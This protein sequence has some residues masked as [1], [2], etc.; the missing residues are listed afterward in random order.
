MSPIPS[1]ISL[2]KTLTRMKQQHTV[3]ACDLTRYSLLLG[4]P[5]KGSVVQNPYLGS[6]HLV[7]YRGQCC[8]T[9]KHPVSVC[10]YMHGVLSY[11]S[12]AKMPLPRQLIENTL[13]VAYSLT[14]LE[15][16]TIMA[17]GRYTWC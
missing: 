10:M 9:Q 6:F 11:V 17:I 4:Y 2:G 12:T 14:R 3:T 5:D 8:S 7:M 13:C 16:R 15:S 1:K